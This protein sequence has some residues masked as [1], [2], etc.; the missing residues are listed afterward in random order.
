MKR[1]KFLLLAVF[2]FVAMPL[3][4]SA[5]D[6]QMHGD[7]NNRFTLYNNHADLYNSH[8]LDD[9]T[10]A[11]AWGEAK[12]RMWWDMS[13]NEGKVKGVWAVE[14]GGLEYGKAGGV[15]KSVG[16]GFSGDGV[17]IETRWLYTDFKLPWNDHMGV[18]MGLFGLK[19]NRFFWAETQMGVQLYGD[20]NNVK[21][22]LGWTRG[23]RAVVKKENDDTSDLNSF[24]LKL[25]FKPTNAV[26]L[27]LFADY[28]YKN[29]D[30]TVNGNIAITAGKKEWYEVKRVKAA[31]LSIFALG[32]NGSFKYDNVF[33]SF[34]FIYE[35]GSIDDANF[36]G[37]M[38]TLN[39]H[40]DFDLNA[41]MAHID[42]GYGF[43]NAKLTYTFWYISGDDNDMDSDFDGFMAVDVD[44]CASKVLM[45]GMMTDDDVFMETGYLGDKG[46]IM[47][48]LAL[49]FK[50]NKKLTVGTAVM[51]MMTAEDMEYTYV[52]NGTT[53]KASADDVGFEWNAYLKYKLYKN[54]EF[55]MDAA[56]LWTGDAMDYY[57]VKKD[58]NADENV[59]LSTARVR[60]KF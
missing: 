34:D 31:D 44:E 10:V 53:Y 38:G 54:L 24:Y 4:V 32:L 58:G 13:T 25:D 46:F 7:L 56:V 11:D 42:L 21:Y 35:G 19:L 33:G 59:F 28:I 43:G 40:H 12:Y 48:K 55:A 2:C 6:I 14:I 8:Q 5:A 30:D 60:Y 16:G 17:N 37:Y 39:T 41:W 47:N 27:S 22:M 49:D 45:E 51:Y 50:A 29:N 52:K 9:G 26:K 20:F 3:L 15:G 36:T 57:E 18:K 23:D 1:V